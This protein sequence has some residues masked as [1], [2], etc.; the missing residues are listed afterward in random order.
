MLLL[1]R[2]VAAAIRA[3]L[4]A[5]WLPPTCRLPLQQD[6][7]VKAEDV[8]NS[9]SRKPVQHWPL[10]QRPHSCIGAFF[11]SSSLCRVQDQ[12]TVSTRSLSFGHTAP[13]VQEGSCRK[14]RLHLQ[15]L[16][17]LE[18]F[19]AGVFQLVSDTVWR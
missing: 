14:V 5:P 6:V 12:G 17:I 18:G 11:T 8:G 19:P 9:Q 7:Q 2:A 10:Q 13:K 3:Q 1:Q 16:F 4:S 15:L